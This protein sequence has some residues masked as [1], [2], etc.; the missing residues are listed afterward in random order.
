METTSSTAAIIVGMAA[1]D[2]IRDPKSTYCWCNFSDNESSESPC[3]SR[4]PVWDVVGR[5]VV[6]VDGTTVISL[7]GAPQGSSA[8]GSDSQTG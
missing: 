1:A 5:M 7:V 3:D 8:A 2:L 6:R 4:V